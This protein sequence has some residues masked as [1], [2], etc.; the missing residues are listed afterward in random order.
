[1][2]DVKRLEMQLDLAKAEEALVKAKKAK[3]ADAK[4][5]TIKADVRA[6]R[7]A[8][9]EAYPAGAGPGTTVTPAAV[10]SEARVG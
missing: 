6:K 2:T 7:Q 5:R 1:M 9:R 8:Y 3:T 10:N 4:M